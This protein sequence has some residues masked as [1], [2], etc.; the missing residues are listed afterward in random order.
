MVRT[1]LRAARERGLVVSG[2]SDYHGTR[3]NI[4]LG[5]LGKGIAPADPLSELTVLRRLGVSED[6]AVS[7]NTTDR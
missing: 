7:E 6:G 2:G 3:K 4:A 1:L 5:T